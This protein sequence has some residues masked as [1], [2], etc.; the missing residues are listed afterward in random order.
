MFF[1]ESKQPRTSTYRTI[2][3]TFVVVCLIVV[4]A[5]FYISFSWATVTLT[6]HGKTLSRTL[7]VRIAEKTSNEQG[8]LS[9]RII[10]QDLEAQGAFTP[11][12]IAT[13]PQKVRGVITIINKTEKPQPLRET[14][15][16]LT[17]DGTL[18]RTTEFVTV[19]PK[20]SLEV[21]VVADAEG[22]SAPAPDSRFILPGLW[23]GLQDKIVGQG[24]EPKE[25]GMKSVHTLMQNDVDKA[26]E[27]V[28]KKLQTQF[29]SLSNNVL[30]K[31]G[32]QSK[33]IRSVIS[34]KQ[35]SAS[36]DAPV[37]SQTDSFTVTL[38]SRLTGVFFDA[39]SMKD[40][41]RQT[42]EK[43]LESGTNL[44]D[45]DIQKFQYTLEDIDVSSGKALLAVTVNANTI[46]S[47]EYLAL[48]KRSLTGKTS[49]QVTEYFANMPD[50]SDT[51]VTY[52]PFWITRMP[53][54]YDHIHIII[55]KALP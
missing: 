13:V 19:G 16:L 55:E 7:S 41:V 40:Y 1:H 37:G 5:V 4:G 42:L 38:K 3:S 10:T 31:S 21:T 35:L 15:R 33:Y 51:R 6:V 36:L 17:Q 47:A 50:I 46:Q 8:V 45:L 20:K 54:L 34:L 27:E 2:A 44:L 14:T 25:Q 30:S 28:T 9:G 23:P 52:Y 22:G 18:F 12:T 48:K 49:G 43:E 39:E 11:E 24:F 53:L 29:E 26:K 32:F